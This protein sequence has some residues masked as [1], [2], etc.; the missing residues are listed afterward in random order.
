MTHCNSQ[1]SNIKFTWQHS[2]QGRLVDFMD[3]SISIN[4]EDR[5]DYELYQKP[6]DSR[7]SLNFESMVPRSLKVAVATQQ[8]RPAAGLSS[9]AVKAEKSTAKILDILFNNNYPQKVIEG[10][11]E[12]SKLQRRNKDEERVG[13]VTLRLPYRGKNSTKESDGCAPS[14]IY[15]SG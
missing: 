3:L 8:F 10:T 2:Q 14:Q 13:V 1:H 9:N 15:Q 11:Y 7:V 12:H 6:S 4:E 5:L